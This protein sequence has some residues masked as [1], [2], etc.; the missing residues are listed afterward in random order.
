[1]MISVMAMGGVRTLL[2]VLV[3]SFVGAPG[4]AK[5]KGRAH[6]ASPLL[7]CHDHDVRVL[8]GVR[9][10]AGAGVGVRVRAWVG[11]G[12]GMGRWVRA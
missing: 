7:D 8:V 2:V 5:A 11:A 10:R 12:A 6:T 4:Q 1:M 9:A 3:L